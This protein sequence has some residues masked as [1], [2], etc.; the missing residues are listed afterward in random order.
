MSWLT[1]ITAPWSM[2]LR[3]RLVVGICALP[4]V[5]G[6]AKSAW[7]QTVE[8][9]TL[10]QAVEDQTHVEREVVGGR[11]AIYDSRGRIL[12]YSL[13]QAKLEVIQPVPAEN[14]DFIISFLAGIL[15]KSEAD[16]IRD[17]GFKEGWKKRVKSDDAIAH[18]FLEAVD[19]GRVRAISARGWMKELAIRYDRGLH[20]VYYVTQDLD[21]AVAAGLTGILT[22][23]PPKPK[24]LKKE[25]N[26]EEAKKE[27]PPPP[28]PQGRWLKGKLQGLRIHQQARRVYPQGTLAGQVIG[29]VREPDSRFVMLQQREPSPEDLVGRSGVEGWFDKELSGK[30]ARYTGVRGRKGR[31]I[32]TDTQE[33]AEVDGQSVVLTIDSYLQ[34]TVEK[35]L[36]EALRGSGAPSGV[37]IVMDVHT[38]ELLAVAQAPSF[39][40]NAPVLRTYTKEEV[41]RWDSLAFTRPYEPGSTIKPLIAA[42]AFQQGPESLFTRCFADNGKWQVL[43]GTKEKMIEDTHA[44]T[45][46]TYEEAIKYSSNICMGKLALQLG[47]TVL[48][49]YFLKL[50]IGRRTGVIPMPKYRANKDL[51]ETAEY[52]MKLSKQDVPEVVKEFAVAAEGFARRLAG[53]CLFEGTGRLGDPRKLTPIDVANRG[54]GQGVSATPIQMAA[55][56]NTIAN[57]GVWVQPTLVKAFFDSHG[58]LVSQPSHVEERVFS[59]DIAA[60]II[61]A[62]REVV[63]PGGTG[64]SA[65]VYNIEVGGKTGTAQEF[66]N[67]EVEYTDR[68]GNQ[69]KARV[70]AYMDRWSAWFAGIAPLDD[71][72]LTVLVMVDNPH[73]SHT[74]G[75]IAGPVFSKVV[76]DAMAYL[77]RRGD[78]LLGQAPMTQ[79]KP[80][81]QI[82]LKPEKEGKLPAASTDSS[83]V[84]IP[85]FQGMS[86]ARVLGLAASARLSVSVQGT[87][88]AVKQI[89]AANSLVPA[90]ST[91]QVIFGQERPE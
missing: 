29:H 18:S 69:R 20:P 70:G 1:K 73:T 66:I 76:R 17:F 25:E 72:Q 56:I 53:P 49:D 35:H 54:F 84:L 12:A 89:P 82:G 50:R 14:E 34:A 41:S 60:D 43:P 55:A 83:V 90:E 31:I 24:K 77:S 48:N 26:E 13:M 91:V 44:R 39:N 64:E 4:L 67:I 52:F 38:G 33:A 28:D 61:K 75:A 36:T 42:M 32:L 10:R 21:P 3:I 22:F 2:T 47:S 19:D 62:M 6:L 79:P 58:R 63:L 51:F 15:E 8:G 87:G 11:G 86:V 71:P 65:N 57:K 81:K 80:A 45:W 7:L 46:I 27:E 9:E 59:E 23:N 37:A 5:L 40:P 85:D 68:E 74:G 16:V 30:L 88:W 78:P